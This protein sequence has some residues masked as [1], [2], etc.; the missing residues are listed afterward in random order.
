MFFL[1]F[2]GFFHHIVLEMMGLLMLVPLLSYMM[3]W[4]LLFMACTMI[5]LMLFLE[6]LF[7]NVVIGIHFPSYNVFI[8]PTSTDW[9][10]AIRNVMSE[11]F[12]CVERKIML[13]MIQIWAW[14][15]LDLTLILILG[16][17]LRRSLWNIKTTWMPSS[18]VI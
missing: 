9:E 3:A 13:C 14:V 15:D 12:L 10:K 6:L 8:A 7:S 11:L 16:P 18:L 17:C 4:E 2:W 1:F 5:L